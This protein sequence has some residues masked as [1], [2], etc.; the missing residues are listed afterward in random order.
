MKFF[1]ITCL[2]AVA[3]AKH[4]IKHVSSSEESTNISQ[5]KYKQDNN[6]AFQTSQESSSGSSSE[7]TTDS[8]TDEKEHHSSSE[9]FTSIS[10]EKTS[11][12]TVDMG[13]TEIFPE[14]IELSDE[15]KNY[16][17]QLKH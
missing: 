16:L 4:E 11:K 14:E 9:E 6:V 15:E 13:S 2:L 1:I 10:Q 3:L 17:K 12:K 8:L 5:E 7:E